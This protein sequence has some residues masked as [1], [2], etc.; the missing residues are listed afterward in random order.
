M[1]TDGAFHR[2]ITNRECARAQGFPDTYTFTGNRADV[3][4]QIGNAVAVPIARWLGHRVATSLGE[5]LAGAA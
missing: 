5:T 4:R 3:K 2:M 1:T